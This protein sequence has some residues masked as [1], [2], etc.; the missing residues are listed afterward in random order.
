MPALAPRALALPLALALAAAA[1]ADPV[2]ALRARRARAEQQAR[3]LAS[4]PPALPDF[5]HPTHDA[6]T[7]AAEV[8][9][10]VGLDAAHLDRARWTVAR[11]GGGSRLVTWSGNGKALA[12][13]QRPTGPRP[14]VSI[15]H[16]GHQVFTQTLH[17]LIPPTWIDYLAL[18]EEGLV[19]AA[20]LHALEPDGQGGITDRY[21]HRGADVGGASWQ[22]GRTRPAGF[23]RHGRGLIA[24]QRLFLLQ[25]DLVPA[26]LLPW[27]APARLKSLWAPL[28]APQPA[29]FAIL[30]TSYVIDEAAPTRVAS[31]A[32]AR[33]ARR[34]FAAMG[35][36]KGGKPGANPTLVV[37]GI[38]DGGSR[39]AA[40]A[41]LGQEGSL[42]FSVPGAPRSLSA[43]SDGGALAYVH[44]R[45]P[46]PAFEGETPIV[47]EVE[48]GHYAVDSKGFHLLDDRGRT[49][50][51]PTPGGQVVHELAWR[52]GGLEI[53]LSADW[54]GDGD[55]DLVVF[56]PTEA[57]REG[58]R[59][60]H[61]R[62][63][64]ARQEAA[65]RAEAEAARKAAAARK[66]A[67]EAAARQRAE[68]ERRAADEARAAAE[69]AELA[70]AEREAAAQQAAEAAA[71]EAYQQAMDAAREAL[72]SGDFAAVHAHA[73]RALAADPEGAEPVFL[74]A[75][76]LFATG[77]RGEA[78]EP[79][80]ALSERTDLGAL[81]PQ[82]ESL[83]L[84]CE[85]AEA[86]EAGSIV[87]GLRALDRAVTSWP[88][89]QNPAWGRLTAECAARN[90][91]FEGLTFTDRWIEA[92]GAKEAQ[93]VKVELLLGSGDFEEAEELATD[94][95]RADLFDPRA[96]V[97][98]GD[99]QLAGG[100][101]KA[102]LRSYRSA[103]ALAP[104]LPGLK[105]KLRR[106]Q[107]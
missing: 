58:K 7:L 43:S 9:V 81:R 89:A 61:M 79:L 22:I 30:G 92:G 74:R 11:Q 93:R 52:P 99:A 54:D 20:G 39:P 44:G 3:V 47:R 97:L 31:P 87:D 4:A 34:A 72:A 80:R 68:A 98:L 102:A 12:W 23:L 27:P 37:R 77:R 94:L 56:D 55:L 103:Q 48:D 21:E 104:N 107:Q 29:D 8:D 69:A 85:G 46:V 101:A 42:E 53:A 14:E 13:V 91:W 70:R 45:A 40:F 88:E 25:A 32:Y 90:L 57:V 105:L 35:V 36:T 60:L 2:A 28:R 1:Q 82:V 67:R 66:Q 17:Q 19:V 5:L 49:L 96:K 33:D 16:L 84:S 18:D 95:V 50:F 24:R 26:A 78:A 75:W 73:E 76:A 15:W 63:E 64:I 65:A 62:A 41:T 6:E 106:A 38:P 83:L 51:V 100:N 59:V 86:L 10:L 71:A